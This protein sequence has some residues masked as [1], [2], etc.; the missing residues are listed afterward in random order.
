LLPDITELF[1][2]AQ[3]LLAPLLVAS[4]GALGQEDALLDPRRGPLV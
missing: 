2:F 1:F 4:L 3:R